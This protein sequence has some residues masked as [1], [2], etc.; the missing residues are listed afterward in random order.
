MFQKFKQTLTV[1]SHFSLQTKI[2]FCSLLAILGLMTMNI[3]CSNNRARRSD[4]ALIVAIKAGDSQKVASLLAQGSDPNMT[5]SMGQPVILLVTQAPVVA[6]LHGLTTNGGSQII[7]KYKHHADIVRLLIDNGAK[8][9]V[10]NA[11]GWTPLWQ[12]KASEETDLVDFMIKAG[13][14]Q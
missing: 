4:P 6:T 5:N 10:Q 12:A 7:N 8:L 9:N 3:N 1:S 2:C 11:D 13:A 14:T